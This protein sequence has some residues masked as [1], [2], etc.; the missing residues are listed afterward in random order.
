MSKLHNS[1]AADDGIT[2]K[3][4]NTPKLLKDLC[5][6]WCPRAMVVSF[7]LETNPNILIAKAAGA[8][9]KYGVDVVC[10]NI[11]G[12]HREAVTLV[13]AEEDPSQVEVKNEGPMKGDEEICVE[14]SGVRTESVGL[15]VTHHSSIEQPLIEALLSLH[16]EY[17]VSCE[18]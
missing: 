1:K 7:K 10:A 16:S 15:D 8:I 4:R 12:K 2:L 11:L 9:F 18:Q 6:T 17:I 14:V 5:D 13:S 3:L